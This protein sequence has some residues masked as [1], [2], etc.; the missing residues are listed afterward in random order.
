MLWTHPFTS[1]AHVSG[2]P[3]R[4]L[5][6]HFASTLVMLV[7]VLCIGCFC[8]T[9]LSDAA[10]SVSASGFAVASDPEAE[11]DDDAVFETWFEDLDVAG[12]PSQIE[13]LA[14]SC[15]EDT[16]AC[17][18]TLIQRSAYMRRNVRRE[19]ADAKIDSAVSAGR[20]EPCMEKPQ[21]AA[22]KG[23]SR[24]LNT[25]KPSSFSIAH[26]SGRS[27]AQGSGRDSAHGASSSRS[28]TTNSTRL[29]SSSP[30]NHTMA[31]D[32]NL[33]DEWLKIDA[34]STKPAALAA[35]TMAESTTSSAVIPTTT[36]SISMNNSAGTQARRRDWLSCCWQLPFWAPDLLLDFCCSDEERDMVRP[37]RPTEPPNGGDADDS[38]TL[39]YGV[40]RPMPMLM[41]LKV[42]SDTSLVA[43]RSALFSA[44][45]HCAS[46]RTALLQ[47][48]LEILTA[49]GHFPRRISCGPREIATAWL[50]NASGG[51]VLSELAS[52]HRKFGSHHW[53]TSPLF[54]IVLVWASLYTVLL[55][56]LLVGVIFPRSSEALRPG[57][58]RREAG[59]SKAWRE[60]CFAW[61]SASWS[62]SWI[63]SLPARPH[64]DVTQEELGPA[65]CAEDTPDNC[66]NKFKALWELEVQEHGLSNASLHRTL[67]K[68]VGWPKL[69]LVA[70]LNIFV[71]GMKRIAALVAVD[72][73][74]GYMAWMDE[75]RHR[76][77]HSQI[78]LGPPG[79]VA[80]MAY[81]IV[82]LT[83]FITDCSKKQVDAR[84][85]MQIEAALAMMIYNKAQI[86]P[87]G[88][89]QADTEGDGEADVVQLV[90]IDVKRNMARFTAAAVFLCFSPLTFIFM[91]GLMCKHLGWAAPLGLLGILPI[92]YVTVQIAGFCQRMQLAFQVMVDQR[93]TMLCEVFP[94]MRIVKGYGWEEPYEEKILEVRGGELANLKW[95]LLGCGGV[96]IMAV[97]AP[98]LLNLSLLGAHVWLYG[99]MDAHRLF[100]CMQIMGMLTANTILVL[101]SLP[102]CVAAMTSLQRVERYL[103]QPELPER[104]SNR[105]SDELEPVR[106]GAPPPAVRVRGNFHWQADPIPVLRD[107]NIDIQHGAFVAVVGEVGSGKSA[108]LQAILGELQ[109]E[110]SAVVEI[111]CQ[112]LAYNAQVPW[113][114]QGTLKENIILD[115]EGELDDERYFAV[116]AAAALQPDLETLPGADDV[117]VG[118]RGITLSGGQRMRTS[119]ARSAYSKAELVLMDNPFAA[120]DGC[121]AQVLMEQLLTGPLMRK[122]TRIAVVQPDP[123]QLLAFDQVLVLVNGRI[124]THG[125]PSKVVESEAFRS[126][127]SSHQRSGPAQQARAAK[128][129]DP[130]SLKRAQRTAGQSLEE[131]VRGRVGCDAYR[132]LSGRGKPRLL[133]VALCLSFASSIFQLLGDVQLANW[134]NDRSWGEFHGASD[135]VYML[136]CAFWVF[137]SVSALAAA[138][139]YGVSYSIG[140][141]TE[142]FVQV[143]KLL[144]QAPLQFFNTTPL[145]RIITRLS[146]DLSN[147]DQRLFFTAHAISG[148][149]MNC[150]V[151]LCY[152]HG[153][154][155][156]SFTLLAVPF[157]L[158]IV[159]LAKQYCI[160]LL[161]LMYLERTLT[162]ELS[163]HLTEVLDSRISVRALGHVEMFREKFARSLERQLMAQILNDCAMTN[164]FQLRAASIMTFLVTQ[165]ALIAVAHPTYFGTGTVAMCLISLTMIVE[166]LP[167][168]VQE[169]SKAQF[170]MICVKRLQEYSGLQTEGPSVMD[171]D[172]HISSRWVTIQR[173]ALQELTVN[174]P[175][176]G[177][178][179]QAVGADGSVHFQATADGTALEPSPAAL[180]AAAQGSSTGLLVVS[181]AHRITSVNYKSGDAAAMMAELCGGDSASSSALVR[182][183]LE[184]SWLRHGASVQI[185]K[186]VVGYNNSSA[187][188]QG[189][190]LEIEAR[191]RV[192][193]VGPT[194]SGKST[195]L[196]A[197]MRLLETQSGRI[198]IDGMDAKTLGLRTLRQALGLVPQEPVLF[199]GTIRHNVDPF[200]W[201]TDDQVWWAFKCVEMK[202]MIENL[203]SQLDQQIEAGGANL[204]FGQRQLICLAR[205]VVRQPKLLLLDEATSALDPRTQEMVQGV[206]KSVF[207]DCTIIAIAHRLET[208][209]DSDLIVVMDQ[210][211]I[212]EKGSPTALRAMSG[213][214]FARMLSASQGQ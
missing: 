75:M 214:V 191:Q 55:L 96:I 53:S 181:R 98:K 5:Q 145:G 33:S 90:T 213:G 187:V 36:S 78:Q 197:I 105:P 154:M 86:M 119:L 21:M 161:Q 193:I 177:N 84:I 134:A 62:T 135:S 47:M 100:I 132:Y 1:G 139:W 32:S 200:G 118:G 8:Q 201:Y 95:L 156:L 4:N 70:V 51:A 30:K 211:H 125:V 203:P 57:E 168:L 91:F 45:E 108:L 65:C 49:A 66:Y 46:P 56:K 87:M 133:V 143:L 171:A 68:F 158:A 59:E 175:R 64:S 92:I 82:P 72:M 157:Y 172:H 115:H 173:K 147:V 122:R 24:A 18:V 11:S 124:A 170:E 149:V 153:H 2:F 151:L 25:S 178:P 88:K 63:V 69:I 79:I 179:L 93:L 104:Q 85:D 202:E 174:L 114:M 27:G 41:E 34:A 38:M 40:N 58:K 192:G 52:F 167:S 99:S 54:Y 150:V 205:M 76:H 6:V 43:N 10:V 152:V 148:Y 94:S 142:I 107:I 183:Y 198:L 164:W 83:I 14:Y 61:A 188:L 15:L 129:Q 155:P 163:G 120:V 31:I 3:V 185:E 50:G 20:R 137:F 81:T 67:F 195:L 97:L 117:P 89:N 17:A 39:G 71:E 127:L 22:V 121:T 180:N 12:V 176:G 144:M 23:H 110:E 9:T 207:L 109:P 48:E 35:V 194:G 184:G 190:S 116:L 101:G 206:L 7:A 74:L 80:I 28:A 138:T 103:R 106:P 130:V 16:Q 136:S 162:S 123:E 73:F 210:G 19:D 159:W 112:Q 204:S 199:S 169:F 37:V 111:N 128:P 182:L 113:L 26:L 13:Q 196:I 102:I 160:T 29:V 146:T 165:V 140:V 189:I 60:G 166:L 141:S 42:A 44:A 208:V 212:I 131:E 126:L 186:L 209:L 77:P